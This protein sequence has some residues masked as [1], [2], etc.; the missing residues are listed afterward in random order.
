MTKSPPYEAQEAAPTLL[1]HLEQV[2]AWT[3]A[4]ALDALGAY[5]LSTEA[6]QRLRRELESGQRRARAA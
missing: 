6:G 4:C 2:R 1:A 3:E 5:L